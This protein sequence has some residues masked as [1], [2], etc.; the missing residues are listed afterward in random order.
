MQ[1]TLV[2]DSFEKFGYRKRKVSTKLERWRFRKSFQDGQG[3]VPS[4]AVVKDQ[5]RGGV[6]N[7]EFIEGTETWRVSSSVSREHCRPGEARWGH[8]EAGRVQHTLPGTPWALTQSAAQSRRE[9]CPL[10]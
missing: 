2:D 4:E 10:H 7:T 1:V 3:S 5:G 8:F 6:G 9:P